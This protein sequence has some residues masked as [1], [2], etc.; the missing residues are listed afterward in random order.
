MLGSL[1]PGTSQQ[2]EKPLS[3][4]EVSDLSHEEEVAL[5]QTWRNVFGTQL[6]YMGTYWCSGALF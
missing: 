3:S 4:Q 5:L 2:E 6:I 1:C